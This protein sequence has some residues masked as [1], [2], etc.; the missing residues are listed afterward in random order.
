MLKLKYN[1][2]VFNLKDNLNIDLK[3]KIDK[4]TIEYGKDVITYHRGKKQH[5]FTF[6]ELLKG[7]IT[8]ERFS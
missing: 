7:D 8:L 2:K 5:T 4:V 6:E 1:N 3:P